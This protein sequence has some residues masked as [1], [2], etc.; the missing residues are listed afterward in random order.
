MRREGRAFA[1]ETPRT[2]RRVRSFSRTTAR[3]EAEKWA[4]D[5]AGRSISRDRAGEYAIVVDKLNHKCYLIAGAGSSRSTRD[6]GGTIQDKIRAGDRAT[7]EGCTVSS[8]SAA[9]DR[10]SN[11][12]ALLINY[13]TTRTSPTSRGE[14]ER[15]GLAFA[16]IA[17]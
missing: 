11:Y 17:V 4:K 7:P 12:K 9:A 14:E 6:L 15:M 10:R 8:R 5:P 16:R 2:S 1:K 3:A 13:P